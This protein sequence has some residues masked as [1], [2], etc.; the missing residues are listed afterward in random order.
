MAESETN[1]PKEGGEFE[2]RAYVLA[3]QFHPGISLTKNGYKF[4]ADIS[5]Y[6]EARTL[7]LESHQWQLSQPLGNG[8]LQLTVAPQLIQFEVHQPEQRLEWI[9][10]R[11]K[12][13]L[14]TFTD[15]FKP[16]VMLMQAA[17]VVGTRQIDGDARM[18]LAKHVSSLDTKRFTML[19][20]PI[21]IFGIRV[22]CPP[23]NK[24]EPKKGRKKQV[25]TAVPFNVDIKAESWGEDPTK[26]WLEAD[27]QWPG[28]FQW[29]S[30]NISEAVGHL[31]L[32]KDYLAKDVMQ[33]LQNPVPGDTQ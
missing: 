4:A 7:S 23:Y 16:K 31:Q 5:D 19:N 15:T 22:T 8:L 24:A 6:L 9:A 21:H 20:R 10:E 3:V 26:L 11:C 18:F 27:A 29:D 25:V 13:V 28:P 12:M 33:F 1:L 2:P 30:K 17:K 14:E 32:V